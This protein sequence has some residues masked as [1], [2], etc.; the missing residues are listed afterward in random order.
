M[1]EWNA[2]PVTKDSSAT[3]HRGDGVGGHRCT[4]QIG[5]REFGGEN[6]RCP[7]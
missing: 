6:L 3:V 4:R 2:E 1:E 7:V 5:D